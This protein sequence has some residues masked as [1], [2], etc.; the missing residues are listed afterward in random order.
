MSLWLNAQVL[1]ITSKKWVRGI[2]TQA[3]HHI[4]SHQ[5]SSFPPQKQAGK[6]EALL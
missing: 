1:K 2:I 4:E 3:Q 6:Q 5:L